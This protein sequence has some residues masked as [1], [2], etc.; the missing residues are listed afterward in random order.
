MAS[1]QANTSLPSTVTPGNP[2]PS[3]LT[4]MSLTPACFDIGTEMAYRLFSHTNTMGSLW[5]PAK[6][7]ASCQSPSLVAPSPNQ[8]P[9]TASSPRYFMA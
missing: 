4:E 6:L 7:R 8:E 2:Y 3:A 9:T 1:K 5:M